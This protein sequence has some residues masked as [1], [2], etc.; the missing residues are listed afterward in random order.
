MPFLI[1]KD[2]R[3]RILRAIRFFA[4]DGVVILAIVLVLE[5]AVRTLAPGYTDQ[6]FDGEFTGGHPRA[7]NAKGYRGELVADKH[8]EGEFRILGIGDSVTWGTSVA[9]ELTWPRQ[10]ADRLGADKHHKVTSINAG[11]PG[12]GL[13]DIAFN[14]DQ[15][16]R[17][18]EPDVIVLALSNNMVSLALLRDGAE[19]RAHPTKP[20]NWTPQGI[21]AIKVKAVR[22]VKRL[23]LPRFAK[24][25]IERA[26]YGIGLRDHD[27]DPK[28]PYGPMLAFGW[29]QGDV[30]PFVAD[31]A[32]TKFEHDLRRLR[33]RAEATGRPFYV[34]YVPSRFMVFDGV[35]DNEKHVPK[36]RVTVEPSEQIRSICEE[37]EIRYVDAFGALRKA[38][39]RSLD[40]A[41]GTEAFFVQFDFTH[42]NE[43]GLSVLAEA[44]AE[45]LK[46]D[47]IFP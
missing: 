20:N 15:R 47:G 17:N 3:P 43:A 37:L 8:A 10:L 44:V 12:H 36:D 34:T 4:V 22:F 25:N 32:W 19:P 40:S 30:P 18:A 2:A 27:V 26:M 28:E 39:Q 14:L 31:H 41:D 33:D 6:I 38:R 7:V 1:N 5:L 13:A 11:Y 21:N 42:L 29:K 9:A 16:W 45:R 46:G 35:W 23:A 24:V